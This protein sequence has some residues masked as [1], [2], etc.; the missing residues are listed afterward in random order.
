LQS[1][2]LYPSSYSPPP[3][4]LAYPPPRNAHMGPSSR[5]A[6]AAAAVVAASLAMVG[7]LW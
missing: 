3:R 1:S 2:N 7:L 5:L 4:A 6:I